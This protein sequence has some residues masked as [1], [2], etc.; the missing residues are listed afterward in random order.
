LCTAD[1]PEG[2]GGG[3]FVVNGFADKGTN[4]EGP[5]SSHYTKQV[6]LFSACMNVVSYLLENGYIQF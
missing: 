6:L 4:A 1:F 2:E 5:A 3:H